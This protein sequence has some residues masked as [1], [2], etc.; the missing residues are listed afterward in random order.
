VRVLVVVLAL[1][2]VV[3]VL[4]WIGERHRQ[5][6]I[7]AH[8]TGCT[9]L[10]WDDGTTPRPDRRSL[11]KRPAVSTV[12]LHGRVDR[13]RPRARS[14][15]RRPRP[16]CESTVRRRA[17][18]APTWLVLSRLDAVACGN[19]YETLAADERQAR[20]SPSARRLPRHGKAG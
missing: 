1:A 15:S 14:E 18:S 2:L 3:A 11:V 6:C 20:T 7:S 4:G 17:A 19:V 9:I 16:P 5:N 10:L 8:K 13:A 12:P